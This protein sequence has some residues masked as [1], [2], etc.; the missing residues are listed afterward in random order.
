V[1]N[2]IISLSMSNTHEMLTCNAVYN[3]KIYRCYRYGQERSVFAYRL[4]TEGTVEQKVYS[5]AV[6]KSN[7]ALSLVDGKN[8]QRYF[9]KEE[10]QDLNQTDFWVGCDRCGRWRIFPP[11]CDEDT[12]TLPDKVSSEAA[13]DKRYVLSFNRRCAFSGTVK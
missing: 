3:Q 13:I 4:L 5:R 7:L 8:L 11:E 2:T 10:T 9:T 6:E 12:S 1:A